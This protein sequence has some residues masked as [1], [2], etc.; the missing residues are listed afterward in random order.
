[1]VNPTPS[2]S[3]RALVCGAA[4]SCLLLFSGCQIQQPVRVDAS[5]NTAPALA[6]RGPSD[7]A[8]LPIEDG[9]KDHAVERHLTFLRQ[10]VMRQLPDRLF[11]PLRSEIVDASLRSEA[12][13]IGES[14]L[15]PATLQRIAGRVREDALLAIRVDTWDESSL[16]TNRRVKFAL[17]AALVGSDGQQLWSGSLKG[18]VK[19]GGAGAAPL[20]RDSAARSCAE[21]A[22][23]ELLLN[24]PRRTIQ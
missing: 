4:I 12:A 8:V 21:L 7:I 16:M 19:A 15:T 24:L 11:T 23:R 22:V 10:E 14:M 6:T 2:Q 13:P 18:D 1:M 5:F 9:T 17:Q 3:L 20:G